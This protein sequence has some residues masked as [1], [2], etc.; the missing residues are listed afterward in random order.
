MRLFQTY[1]L[2]LVTRNLLTG[3]LANRLTN[4]ILSISFS[5]LETR[6]RNLSLVTHHLSLFFYPLYAKRY[7]LYSILSL[8]LP[9]F[10]ELSPHMGSEE[11]LTSDSDN[12][13]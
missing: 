7:T 11:T 5:K 8:I 9:I 6:N 3:K 10:P 4:P 1:N 2:Q 12:Q 13:K